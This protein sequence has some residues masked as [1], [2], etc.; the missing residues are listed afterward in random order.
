M[1]RMATMAPPEGPLSPGK[2]YVEIRKGVYRVAETRVSL[3]SLVQAFLEGL[4][5]EEIQ[6]CFPVLSLEQVYGALAFYLSHR[7]EVDTYLAQA[8]AEFEQ[9]RQRWRRSNPRLYNKLQAAR[10][11]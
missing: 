8:D 2:P 4:S 5:A 6:D 11:S 10:P 3:D 9:L 7:S 1:L